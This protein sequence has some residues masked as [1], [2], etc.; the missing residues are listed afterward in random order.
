MWRK[1]EEDRAKRDRE[2]RI[3]GLAMWREV[4]CLS[5]ESGEPAE[6]I[7]KRL[8]TKNWQPSAS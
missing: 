5:K 6:E 1:Y 4:E 7:F 3:E 8:N 2:L